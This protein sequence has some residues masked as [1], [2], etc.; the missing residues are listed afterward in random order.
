MAQRAMLCFL[1]TAYAVVPSMR[2]DAL[3]L[4]YTLP[5]ASLPACG[6]G[7]GVGSTQR[8]RCQ[9]KMRCENTPCIASA[10][11]WVG[12]DVFCANL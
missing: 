11:I 10:T 1:V 5:L 3:C 6:E 4:C 2:F 9:R 12:N 7:T 8:R